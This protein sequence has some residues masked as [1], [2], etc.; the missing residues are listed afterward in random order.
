MQNAEIIK[1]YIP[2]WGGIAE[3]NL[4]ISALCHRYYLGQRA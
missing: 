1:E 3:V 2:P 4:Q